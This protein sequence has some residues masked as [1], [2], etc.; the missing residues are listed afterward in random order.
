[1]ERSELF[2]IGEVSKLFHI[3]ISTLRYYDKIGIKTAAIK[4][5]GHNFAPEQK[6]I[7]LD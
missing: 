4:H 3:S 6:R 1:M 5:D 2:Q 7:K